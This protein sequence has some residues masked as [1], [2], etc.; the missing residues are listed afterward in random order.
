MQLNGDTTKS[1]ASSGRRIGSMKNKQIIDVFLRMGFTQG[2]GSRHQVVLTDGKRV[3][4]V[5]NHTRES[6]PIDIKIILRKA[7]VSEKEFLAHLK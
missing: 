7:K 4:Q 2:I 3:A 6:G 1:S 5:Q